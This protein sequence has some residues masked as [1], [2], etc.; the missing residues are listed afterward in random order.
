MKIDL[1]MDLNKISERSPIALDTLLCDR[2]TDKSILDTGRDS[3]IPYSFIPEL[4]PRSLRD[5]EVNKD[6]SKSKAEIFTPIRIVNQMNTLVLKDWFGSKSKNMNKESVFEEYI[7]STQMEITCGESVFLCTR[8][9][10]ETGEI[11]ELKNR[12]GLLDHKLHKLIDSFFNRNNGRKNNRSSKID[13][14]ELFYSYLIRIDKSIYGY[15]YQGDSLLMA[16]VNN[17]MSYI[18]Y[19]SYL[20]EEEM[21]GRVVEELADIISWNIFQMD[22]LTQ[23]IPQKEVVVDKNNKQKNYVAVNGI[24]VKIMNWKENKIELF[25]AEC[26]EKD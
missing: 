18:D 14:K 12:V 9:D 25:G 4:V 24:G 2:T 3:F 26:V 11:I 15:E 8:Y 19:Y 10:S 20:F 6:R 13:D 22:G 17:L 5:K 21:G 23:C 16:R 7:D 1:S